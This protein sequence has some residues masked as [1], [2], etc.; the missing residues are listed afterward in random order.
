M[1]E[2]DL[3]CRNRGPA[4]IVSRSASA[5]GRRIQVDIGIGLA[6]AVPKPEMFD[7]IVL[8][9]AFLRI[10]CHSKFDMQ[11]FGARDRLRR[12]VIPGKLRTLLVRAA[13]PHFWSR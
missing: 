13:A 1:A 3:A 12:I 2:Q 11:H 6:H 10:V 4:A 8:A 7:A 5:R 9:L